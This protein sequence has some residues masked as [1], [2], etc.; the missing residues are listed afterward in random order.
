MPIDLGEPDTVDLGE[1]DQHNLGEPDAPSGVAP[2]AQSG[3]IPPIAPANVRAIGSDSYGPLQALNDGLGWVGEKGRA[4]ANKAY[5]FNRGLPGTSPASEMLNRSMVSAVLG[6]KLLED[7]PEGDRL[8]AVNQLEDTFGEN[9]TTAALVGSQMVGQIPQ[10]LMGLGWAK[11]GATA[12]KA[13]ELEGKVLPKIAQLGAEGLGA[14]AENVVVGGTQRAIKGE[15][16][17][18]LQDFAFG[19]G[20]HAAGAGLELGS[21]ELASAPAGS[22]LRKFG[23]LLQRDIV[24]EAKKAVGAVTKNS[25]RRVGAISANA[26]DSIADEVTSGRA[27]SSALLPPNRMRNAVESIPLGEDL[28]TKVRPG[29]LDPSLVVFHKNEQGQIVASVNEINADGERKY[30]ETPV[31]TADDASRLGKFIL[32]KGLATSVA[33]DARKEF[34]SLPVEIYER[35]VQHPSRKFSVPDSSLKGTAEMRVP[36]NF[37]QLD[38]PAIPSAQDASVMVRADGH[39]KL[40]PIEHDVVDLQSLP[41]PGDSVAFIGAG[42]QRTHATYKGLDPVTNKAIIHIGN[43]MDNWGTLHQVHPDQ[44]VKIDT[45]SVTGPNPIPLTE[46]VEPPPGLPPMNGN[47]PREPRRGDMGFIPNPQGGYLT[48]NVVGKGEKPG[49]LQVTVG[50]NSKPFS[51]DAT[52]VESRLPPGIQNLDQLLP[53]T[54]EPPSPDVLNNLQSDDIEEHLAAQKVFTNLSSKGPGVYEKITNQLLGGQNRGPQVM[55]DLHLRTQG[56]DALFKARSD[57]YNRVEELLPKGPQRQVFNRDLEGVIQGRMSWD[58]MRTKHGDKVD[59]ALVKLSGNFMDSRR[60][61]EGEINALGGQLD[62]LIAERAAGNIEP[63]LVRTYMRD[64]LPQGEWAKMVQKSHPEVFSR[65]VDYLYKE[66]SNNGALHVLPE[67]VSAELEKIL[68]STNVLEAMRSSAFG[69]TKAFKSMLSRK[70]IPE[71][72]RA[73]MGEVNSASIRMATTLGNMEGIKARLEMFDQIAKDQALSSI[74]RR[75][76]MHPEPVPDVPR[77][78]GHLA[79][80]YVKPE[81]RDELINLPNAMGNTYTFANQFQHWLKGNQ[82]AGFGPWWTSLMGNLQGSM[83]SGGLSLLRPDNMGRDLTQAVRAWRDYHT[84]PTGR[85][86]D[87]FLF[88]EFKKLGAGYAGRSEVEVGSSSRKFVQ[89]LLKELETSPKGGLSF[90]DTMKKVGEKYQDFTGGF[91][92]LL[93]VQ[94]QFFRLANYIALRRKFMAKGMAPD[95]AGLLASKR[96]AASFPNSEFLGSAIKKFRQSAVGIAAPYITPK[97]EDLRILGNLPKRLMEEP[98]LGIRIAGHVALMGGLGYAMAHMSGISKEELALARESMTKRYQTYKTALLPMPFRDANGR[99]Q[100][101]D[102]TNYFLPFQLLQGHPDDSVLN[103]LA[104]NFSVF[105]LEGGALQDTTDMLASK[106]GLK[107]PLQTPDLIEGEGNMKMLLDAAFRMGFAPQMA[108]KVMDVGRMTDFSSL[109]PPGV[110]APG[111]I[112]Q[113]INPVTLGPGKLGRSEEPLTPGQGLVTLGGLKPRGFGERGFQGASKER[114]GQE[115]DL[116]KKQVPMVLKSNRD[117]EEKK[118]LMDAIFKR[119]QELSDQSRQAADVQAAAQGVRK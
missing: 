9:G 88:K 16:P 65:A 64:L 104:Y 84:D 111:V 45:D 113:P 24:E 51:I 96:I 50:P 97:A 95:E 25:Y 46:V 2:P 80:R 43:D 99:V 61:L 93:D 30:Y 18:P 19:A 106:A 38:Q 41:K 52:K 112:P 14:G 54:P 44:L 81:V 103:R 73:V 100:F 10:M 56:S 12:A 31:Q 23:D 22:R 85:A 33:T 98:D 26:L 49:T 66:L 69:D 60:Q 15:E 47:P 115:M 71:P 108:N 107:R 5:D 35:L 32:D 11:K 90:I 63:Y 76:D 20:M 83:L 78:F 55:R 21:R 82:L 75:A 72:I 13:L 114:L 109:V 117:P 116:L 62:D 42:G 101:I 119:V 37:P 94:D 86:G 57:L 6:D 89:S 27:P 58:D 53:V 17:A 110:T 34:S 59:E 48:V 39:V 28:G 102:V 29:E 4:L 87:G 91:G 67:Q 77:M 118:R 105:P 36:N 40:Q 92:N 8:K 68:R 74:G 3:S 7:Q 70:D 79:G 1:P